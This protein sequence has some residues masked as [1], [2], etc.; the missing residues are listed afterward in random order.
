[1]KLRFT[2]NKLPE[3]VSALRPLK[4]FKKQAMVVFD[5]DFVCVYALIDHFANTLAVVRLPTA[6]FFSAYTFKYKQSAL[7]FE[8][9][10]ELLL[11]VLSTFG[12]Y[13][14]TDAKLGRTENG[15]SLLFSSKTVSEPAVE[16]K[17]PLRVLLNETIEVLREPLVS[18]P[19]VSFS[20]PNSS[21]LA[22]VECIQHSAKTVQ[23]HFSKDLLELCVEEPDCN[24]KLLLRTDERVE[25]TAEP[26]N[27]GFVVD[28]STICLALT[29]AQSFVFGKEVRVLVFPE[30]LLLV[31]AINKFGASFTVFVP[32]Q[33]E[34]LS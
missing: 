25:T 3:A 32:V 16:Q 4:R 22:V 13:S 26:T 17:L 28:L 2:S 30:N 24:L 34:L 11:T 12:K 23:L 6:T 9:S 27:K 21:Q 15:F 1:M 29:S 31:N 19:L 20:L 18:V 7:G 10:L 5:S 14:N 8:L 33:S